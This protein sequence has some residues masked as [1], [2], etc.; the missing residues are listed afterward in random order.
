MKV[1]NGQGNVPFA[2]RGTAWW[3]RKQKKGREVLGFHQP[4]KS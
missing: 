3:S 4:L 1:Q 2:V